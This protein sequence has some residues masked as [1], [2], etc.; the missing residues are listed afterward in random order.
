MTYQMVLLPRNDYWNW[1]K[2]SRDFVLAFGANMTPDPEVV[3]RSPLDDLVVT[4]PNGPA[5]FPE[6]G[7][8]EKWLS[9]QAP[10]LRLNPIPASTAEEFYDALQ[11]RVHA[12]DPFGEPRLPISLAWPTDYPVITQPFGAN[13]Q[14]YAR[15][16]LPGHEGID[17]R[18][19]ANT[20]VYAAAAGEVYEVHN[21]PGGHVYGIHVRLRHGGGFKSTY[22]HLAR[23]LVR[24]GETVGM[25]QL[26]GKADSTGA[27]NAS[28]LHLLLKKDG[29]TARGETRYPRDII[30]PSPFLIRPSANISKS[31]PGW[32]WPAAKTLLGAVG[33]PGDILRPSDIDLSIR[34]RLE[35][36]AIERTD[37]SDAVRRLTRAIPGI[38]ILVRLGVDPE[39]EGAAAAF[40]ERVRDDVVRWYGHGVRHFEVQPNPN[41]QSGGWGW[42]WR[43]GGEF[44]RWFEE[45]VS[46]LR[47]DCGEAQFGFPCLSPGDAVTGLRHDSAAF[48]DQADSAAATA[49]WIGVATFWENSVELS[50]GGDRRSSPAGYR[51]HFP[52][53]PLFV[54][55]FANVSPHSTNS[56]RAEQYLAFYEQLR[57]VPGVGAAFAYCLS[58]PIA[59]S[60]LVWRG[61]DGRSHGIAEAIGGRSF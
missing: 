20:N 36:I 16:G 61:E 6:L 52:H 29:A 59:H 19:L 10:Q 26:I 51:D 22:A 9:A 55:E 38:F 47:V 43:D 41:L 3:V 27:S 53:R 17:F 54:T 11:P 12:G 24:V 58:S 49:D 46:G 32:T 28:H 25:G 35:A 18:A 42:G 44:G 56:Q 23:A 33:R 1:V 8:T 14:I 50:R 45:V 31:P 48:L 60:S 40:V 37:R 4:F 2:A 7:D 57:E 15:Y 5:V 39:G 34:A 30:D 13:P 21:P